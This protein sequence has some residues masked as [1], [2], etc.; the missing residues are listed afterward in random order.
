MRASDQ[1]N[2]KAKRGRW[3]GAEN[4]TEANIWALLDAVAKELLMG[5]WGWKAVADEYNKYAYKNGHIL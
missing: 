1:G 3:S 5:E 2:G 4:S